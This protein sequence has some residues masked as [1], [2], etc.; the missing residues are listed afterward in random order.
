MKRKNK[1]ITLISLIVTIIIL[2]ILSGIVISTLE[3]NEFF[4]KVDEAKRKTEN[5][6]VNE[7][8]KLS[9]YEMYVE[10]YLSSNRDS[11]VVSKEEYEEL[12]KTVLALSDKINSCNCSYATNPATKESSASITNP[13]VVVENYCDGAH[14]YRVWSDGWIEQG[15]EATG[16]NN[17]SGVKVDFLKSFN[18]TN[19]TLLA[20]NL[21]IGDAAARYVKFPQRN[22]S[23]FYAATGWVNGNGMKYESNNFKW[24]ACGY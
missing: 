11:V 16:G 6:Q 23:N 7:D 1:G 2:L 4:T 21:Y 3:Q 17:N 20:Q 12:K 14:W 18:T 10:G 24:Y 8:K 15:G 22:K 9:D 19:Y 13:C 5:E